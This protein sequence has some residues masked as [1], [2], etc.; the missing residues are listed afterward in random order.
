MDV[1]FVV[2]GTIVVNNQNKLLY[3]QAPGRYGSGHKEFDFSWLEIYNGWIPKN[4]V[5]IVYKNYYFYSFCVCDI[6]MLKNVF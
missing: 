2:V 6:L 5:K 1:V 4:G 3:V